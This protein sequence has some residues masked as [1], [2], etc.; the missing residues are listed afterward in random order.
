MK[1]N[2]RAAR[3]ALTRS[4]TWEIAPG[5]RGP[6]WCARAAGA[7]LLDFFVTGLIL[8]RLLLKRKR[9]STERGEHFVGPGGQRW[10]KWSQVVASGVR[11][12]E[13]F[14]RRAKHVPGPS[15][16]DRSW[17]LRKQA[18]ELDGRRLTFCRGA[19]KRSRSQDWRAAV[20]STVALDASRGSARYACSEA[21]IACRIARASG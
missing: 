16:S 12:L 4:E 13:G 18:L 14:G 1:Q 7:R 5:P 8:I 9:V 3:T 10:T 19:A 6:F 2:R 11:A 20:P 15:P 17:P 21:L